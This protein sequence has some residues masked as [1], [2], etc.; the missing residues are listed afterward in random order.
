MNFFDQNSAPA[1]SG[2]L[3]NYAFRGQVRLGQVILGSVRLVIKQEIFIFL[4]S[5]I[6]KI[7]RFLLI[8]LNLHNS[9]TTCDRR[10]PIVDLESTSKNRL[11]KRIKQIMKNT[12]NYQNFSVVFHRICLTPT[13][14]ELKH[15]KLFSLHLATIKSSFIYLSEAGIILANMHPQ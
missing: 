6:L 11:I 14:V 9:K 3:A 13:K 2:N 12:R 10:K 4:Y 1:I 5:Y 8:I 7:G 15:R